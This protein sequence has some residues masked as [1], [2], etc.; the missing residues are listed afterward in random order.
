[1]KRRQPTPQQIVR[2]FWEAD[3]LLGDGRPMVEVSK[4][5]QIF[6]LSIIIM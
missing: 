2:K 3:Q 5:L 1:M 4:H 6:E